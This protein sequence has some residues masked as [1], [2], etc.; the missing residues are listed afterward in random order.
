DNDDGNDSQCFH[1][2]GDSF[3]STAP[4][5]ESKTSPGIEGGDAACASRRRFLRALKVNLCM[6]II[7]QRT[8]LGVLR[9]VEVALRL[10]DKEV[11]GQADFETALLGVQP[12]H[13]ELA[14]GPGRLVT[15]KVTFDLQRGVG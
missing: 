3:F 5:Q 4:Y 14:R 8:Q 15:L 12:R 13:R 6:A 9:G 2:T 1:E 11:G 7:E 10:H